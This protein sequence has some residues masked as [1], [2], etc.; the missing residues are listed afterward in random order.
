MFQ[1][2]SISLGILNFDLV[3]IYL[4]PTLLL[5]KKLMSV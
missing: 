2:I 1:S 4:E 5:L 3:N